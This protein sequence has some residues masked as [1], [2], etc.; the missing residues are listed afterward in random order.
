MKMDHKEKLTHDYKIEVGYED[1]YDDLM[2]KNLVD[3]IE[4]DIKSW[5]I[6]E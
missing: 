5:Q 1:G 4:L 2:Y 3:Y 6:V